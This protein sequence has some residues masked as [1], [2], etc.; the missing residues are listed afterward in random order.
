MLV[1]GIG[2]REDLVIARLSLELLGTVRAD[3]PCDNRTSRGGKM[4]TI[5]ARA[6]VGAAVVEWRSLLTSAAL[7]GIERV[8][9]APTNRVAAARP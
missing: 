4:T 7:P 5:E 1:E 8:G 3:A 2:D 9:E 6:N